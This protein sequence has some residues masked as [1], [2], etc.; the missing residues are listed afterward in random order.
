MLVPNLLLDHY[1][2][3]P[4]FDADIF[5]ELL[6]SPLAPS[7]SVS[8][9]P[10]GFDLGTFTPQGLDLGPFMTGLYDPIPMDPPQV[11]ADPQTISQPNLGELNPCRFPPKVV[12]SLGN[13]QGYAQWPNPFLRPTFDAPPAKAEQQPLPSFKPGRPP[14]THTSLSSPNHQPYYEP[15]KKPKRR[16]DPLEPRRPRNAFILYRTDFLHRQ[17][18]VDAQAQ[19]SVNQFALE[20]WKNMS[21][22]EKMHWAKLAEEDRQRYYR[23]KEFRK[24]MVSLL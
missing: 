8:P 9:S 14:S 19:K 15:A 11:A 16:R 5:N 7:S 10:Q 3:Y 4:P 23:E 1:N 22:M 21:A 18:F 2:L 6:L 12:S 17:S 24:A 13:Y 20:S